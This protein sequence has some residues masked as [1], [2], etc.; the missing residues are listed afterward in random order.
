[1]T[2]E[3]KCDQCGKVFEA[4]SRR[5]SRKRFCSAKCRYAHWEAEA[6]SMLRADIEALVKKYSRR[7]IRTK[8]EKKA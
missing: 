2:V 7:G 8:E 1:M 6:D 3:G 4:D 5:A